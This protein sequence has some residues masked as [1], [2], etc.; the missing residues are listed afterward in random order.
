MSDFAQ[1]MAGSAQPLPPVAGYQWATTSAGQ[2]ATLNIL[3]N[4][5]AYGG[6]TVDPTTIDLDPNTPGQQTS[7]AVNGGVFNVVNGT[8]EFTP[9]SS[10]TG[11]ATASYTVAD[12]NQMVSNVG[13]LLVT[14]NPALRGWTLLDS[15]ESGTDGWGPLP[16]NPPQA[17]GTVALSPAFHTDGS[18]SLQVNVTAAGWFGV[19]FPSPVDL[20]NWP[21]L[22]VDVGTTTVGTYSAFA[23]QS[24]SSNLWCQNNSSNWQPLNLF[25]TTTLAIPLQA[26]YLTCYSNNEVV[27][28]PPPDLTRVSSLYVYFGNPGTY[29]LDYLRGAPGSAGA[30]P[31][32]V[33]GGVS[34]S[35]GGQP[36]ASAGTYISIYGS[37][38][39]PTGWPAPIWSDYVANGQLPTKLAG[40]SVSIGG[41]PAYVEYVN[42]TQI[43]IL[44]PNLGTGSTSVTV[45]TPAGTSNPFP[46]QSSQVQPA[47]FA[48]QPG[49]YVVATDAS[50][51]WLVE[52]GEFPGKTTAPAQPGETVILWGT[53]FGPTTP[54]APA[55]QV[56]PPN[57]YSVNG[58]V[59]T[60]GTVQVPATATALSPGS[61]G[62]YQIVI[63]LPTGLANGDYPIVATVG[64]VQSPSGVKLTVQQ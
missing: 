28:N 55:G 21:S 34:N 48:W 33:I 60:V 7:F 61:A 54:A 46:I 31:L 24:G 47:F 53:G 6:A 23:F 49:N 44:A 58:V 32:P 8:V 13:Y 59:V 50:Y 3:S 14:V 27:T 12:S 51:N 56:T 25:S 30:A 41:T 38:F 40:V 9:N 42:P 17:A 20:S 45:T 2:P 19:A 11:I 18:Y 26:S 10:F 36:G 1:T 4:D 39:A 63:T 35:A 29:Y 5:V 62:L 16:A 64:G 52:N 37:N 57:I 15:F 22:A 43:N